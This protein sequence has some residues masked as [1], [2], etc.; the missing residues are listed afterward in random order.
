M[1]TRSKSSDG[2]KMARDEMLSDP[3]LESDPKW[4]LERL[5]EENHFLRTAYSAATARAEKYAW[6]RR[7]LMM[8]LCL[9][10]V[11]SKDIGRTMKLPAKT[12]LHQANVMFKRIWRE[13]HR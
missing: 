11:D 6:W 5:S 2:V 10:G 9:E 4:A 7:V 3:T 8:K 1:D 13:A 12:V